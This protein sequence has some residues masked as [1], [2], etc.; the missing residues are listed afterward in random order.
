M[1]LFACLRNA[2][3]TAVL[4]SAIFQFCRVVDV[5][6]VVAAFVVPRPQERQQQHHYYSF[7][8]TYGFQ[9]RQHHQFITCRPNHPLSAQSESAASSPSV[10]NAR[11]LDAERAPQNNETLS[12]KTATS[13]SS[14]MTTKPTTTTTLQTPQELKQTIDQLLLATSSNNPQQQEQENG[15]LTES[16]SETNRLSRKYVLWLAFS[17]KKRIPSDFN[18]RRSAHRSRLVGC[19]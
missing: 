13:P 7:A 12:T 9:D 3:H 5:V 1:R 17:T 4:L 14:W 18:S 6:V 19:I 16:F 2:C 11:S 15:E 10:A 8:K